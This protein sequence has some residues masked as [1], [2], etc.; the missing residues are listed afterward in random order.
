LMRF[1][2]HAVSRVGY[3]GPCAGG[4][5][6]YVPCADDSLGLGVAYSCS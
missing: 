5:A 2:Q 3:A 1:V 6:I 4:S